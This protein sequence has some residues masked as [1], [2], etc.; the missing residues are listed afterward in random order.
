MSRFKHL[1]APKGRY[2]ALLLISIVISVACTHPVE[3]IGN[4]DIV[5]ST[6]THNCSKQQS[7]CNFDIV[8]AYYETYTAIA[9]SGNRFSHWNNC[10]QISGNSCSWAVNAAT[11]QRHWA[12]TMPPMQAVFV[13]NNIPPTL[14]LYASTPPFS[15]NGTQASFYSNISYG[16]HS[17][18]LFDI[19]LPAKNKATGLI[20]YIH[21]GGFI[22]G[23]KTLA[24][25]GRRNEIKE[26][27]NN[28]IAY[29]SI[30]YRYLSNNPEG[31]LASLNDAKR[32][33]QFMR[34]HASS[35]NIDK[36][37]VAV[38]GDSAG[39][40]TSL[41][42]A[43]SNDMSI[44]SSA[45]PVLRETTRV[46]GAASLE[47]QASYDF[48][49][50]ETDVFKTYGL[51]VADIAPPGSGL[52]RRVLQ[53][54]NLSSVASMYQNASAAL[55][56]KL[57]MLAALDNSDPQLFIANLAQSAASPLS[58]S[59]ITH[60]PLHAKLIYQRAQAINHPIIAYVPK[61]GIQHSPHITHV[62]YLIGKVK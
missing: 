59:Q 1:L 37:R 58:Q 12:Q 20:I 17:R 14:P 30:N 47:T 33:L 39:A 50:W 8:G 42:L 23:D 36:S 2:S 26:Y 4:G 19:F 56:S 31:L 41:W 48:L 22:S 44:P 32:A 11:V 28:G 27:L 3:V 10:I 62:N 40:G 16:N 34:Y 15:L 45:D 13:G 7:P 55:R 51:K 29:A 9:H 54:N 18:N 6:G 38:Y 5:S 53:G 49:R 61:L 21:G 24:Y 46:Q 43:V 60:H 25:D 52:E 57:D 35:L